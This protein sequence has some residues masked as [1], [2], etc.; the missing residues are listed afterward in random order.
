MSMT[1]EGEK[2][3]LIEEEFKAKYNKNAPE[4]AFREKMKPTDG[5]LVVFLM[6]LAEVFKDALK[7]K[8]NNENID[9]TIP[10]IGYAIGIPPIDAGLGEDYLIN[11]HIR[12]NEN[13]SLEEEDESDEIEPLENE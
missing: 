4:K 1:L 5:L 7:E 6:D 9:L 13:N 12:E 8:A 10:L 11:V 2:I 3:T